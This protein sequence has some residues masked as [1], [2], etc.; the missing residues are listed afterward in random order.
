M[1]EQLR[2]GLAR[3]RG[4]AAG[5]ALLLPLLIGL[6]CFGA[7]VR[8]R[9]LAASEAVREARAATV[10]V[11]LESVRS[12]ERS[13]LRSLL[14]S[15]PERSDSAVR[16]VLGQAGWEMAPGIYGSADPVDPAA[17]PPVA[18][19][20]LQPGTAGT[21]PPGITGAFVDEAVREG[22][23]TDFAFGAE[24]RLLCGIRVTEAAG[25]S[26]GVILASRPAEAVLA[27]ALGSDANVGAALYVEGDRVLTDP[28]PLGSL[29]PRTLDSDLTA[30]VIG[31]DRPR[32][33]NPGEGDVLLGAAVPLKDFEAWDVTAV[34]V[35]AMPRTELIGLDAGI[36]FD[37]ALICLLLAS[38]AAW[39]V[40]RGAAAEP[41]RRWSGYGAIVPVAGGA[42]LLR[43]RL[44]EAVQVVLEAGPESVHAALAEGGLVERFSFG[45]ELTLLGG[46]LAFALWV[47][48]VL[49]TVW[50][51]D[52]PRVLRTTFIA[53]AFLTPAVIGLVVFFV[54]PMLF[55]LY[56]SF[57]EWSIVEPVKPFVGLGN[58]AELV[59][60]SDFGHALWISFLYTLHVPISMT[61]ALGLALLLNRPL[62]GAGVFRTLFFLPSITS[63]V[64]IAMVWEWIYNPDFGLANWMLGLFGMPQS[65][66]LTNPATA[67]PSLMLMAIWIGMGYQMVIFLAG[68]QGIP[69]SLY[70]AAKI[71]G[72]GPVRRFFR[73]TLP[74]LRPTTFFVLVTSII[75]SFQVFT[76][77]YVMTD[78]GPVRAT[79]V[80]VYHIYSA[81]WDQFRMGDAAAMSWVLFAILLVA[82]LLQ[83][84]FVGKDVSYV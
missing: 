46:L 82:T 27:R 1:I 76:Q 11:A 35:V 32:A 78:G 62:R 42:W 73:I 18:A 7:L 23:V 59:R 22:L 21:W 65:G 41:G 43:S 2:H 33:V 16:A 67:L 26:S 48:V 34:L 3:N 6:T 49:L 12:A 24:A 45:A 5:G 17:A 83:F 40:F 38:L 20:A 75:G 84:R 64:A 28:S 58:Y 77:V 37:L 72:A 29:L 74:L 31:E 63:F 70:E 55:A 52:R 71:D 13:L 8:Q 44:Q 66:W 80:V 69:H 47:G 19:G 50:N 30:Q 68:L 9:T 56:I 51:L 15:G 61:L 25:A 60:S 57:H 4:A 10:L 81:A 79:D 54:G 39:L 36:G 14:P 53:G